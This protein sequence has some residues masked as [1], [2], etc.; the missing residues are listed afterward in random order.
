MHDLKVINAALRLGDPAVPPV[1]AK[2][3]LHGELQGWPSRML[4][5]QIRSVGEEGVV[6]SDAEDRYWVVRMWFRAL[7]G[8]H[9][10]GTL[11]SLTRNLPL[12]PPRFFEVLTLP[13]G[14]PPF[15]EWQRD[16]PINKVATGRVRVPRRNH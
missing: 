9:R 11:N 6:T 12:I 1:G 7:T 13:K 15:E 2:C 16:F 3:Y 14:S 5:V 10:P 4:L 8:V